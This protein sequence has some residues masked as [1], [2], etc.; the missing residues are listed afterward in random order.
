MDSAVN[1]YCAELIKRLRKEPFYFNGYWRVGLISALASGS[2]LEVIH[3]LQCKTLTP[4][5]CETVPGGIVAI[6][7]M[8]ATFRM[9]GVIQ[10]GHS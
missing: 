7:G 9:P 5:V 4:K 10:N 1:K 8:G 2:R 3:V 6:M